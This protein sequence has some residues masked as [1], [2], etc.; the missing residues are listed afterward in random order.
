MI[1]TVSD[2]PLVTYA[3]DPSGV[4]AIAVGL[5]PTGMVAMTALEAVSM[6][7]T[8]ALEKLVTYARVPSGVMAI[9][10]GNKPTGIGKPRTMFNVVSIMETLP[11]VELT[12]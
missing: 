3:R 11:A 9:S 6:T 7:E 2:P 4:M 10:P 8:E 1:D 5:F 12:T